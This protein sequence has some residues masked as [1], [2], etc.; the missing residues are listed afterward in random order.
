[1]GSSAR[2]LITTKSP[3]NYL[4]CLPAI[5]IHFTD[6]CSTTSRQF[7]LVKTTQES[8]ASY[9]ERCPL[10][11][12]VTSH[13]LLGNHWVVFSFDCAPGSQ[14]KQEFTFLTLDFPRWKKIAP[15]GHKHTRTSPRHSSFSCG[16]PLTCSASYAYHL[17][18]LYKLKI[19]NS[20]RGQ[21]RKCT[22]YFSNI[23]GFQ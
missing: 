16:I 18:S 17:K 12:W 11:A 19:Q 20:S 13:I 4:N 6:Q 2:S 5:L 7:I 21:A 9:C 3:R 23:C 22:S 14:T 8:L 15:L 1:M 10:C